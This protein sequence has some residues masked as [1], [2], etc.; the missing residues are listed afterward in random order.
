M[1]KIRLCKPW[2]HFHLFHSHD[3]FIIGLISQPYIIQ[4][5]DYKVIECKLIARLHVVLLGV[6]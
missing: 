1:A 3:P 5:V 4:L 2:M 6:R